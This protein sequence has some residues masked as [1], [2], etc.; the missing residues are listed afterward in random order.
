MI[1]TNTC[2]DNINYVNTGQTYIHNGFCQDG[3]SNSFGSAHGVRLAK[4]IEG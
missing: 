2:D 3:G 4:G 1:C